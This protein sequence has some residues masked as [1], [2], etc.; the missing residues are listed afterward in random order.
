MSANLS[1]AQR[2]AIGRISSLNPQ[3][4][5]RAWQHATDPDRVLLV[6]PNGRTMV[7]NSGGYIEDDPKMEP[8]DNWRPIGNRPTG[9]LRPTR[10]LPAKT[11]PIPDEMRSHKYTGHHLHDHERTIEGMLLE[12]DWAHNIAW[13]VNSEGSHPVSAGSLVKLEPTEG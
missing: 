2:K 12:E 5:V 7:I 10:Q 9:T 3:P 1:P 11:A 6:W 8:P 4:T 13:L